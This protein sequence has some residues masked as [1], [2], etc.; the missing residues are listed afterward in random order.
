MGVGDEMALLVSISVMI[1]LLGIIHVLHPL[2]P[3]CGGGNIIIA[4]SGIL[5]SLT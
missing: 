2:Q 3:S 4:V 5:L 1:N